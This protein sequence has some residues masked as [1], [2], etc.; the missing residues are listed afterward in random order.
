MAH[1]PWRERPDQAA[2]RRKFGVL[3]PSTNSMVEYDFNWMNVPGV[4]P[5]FSRIHIYDADLS[6]PAQM[7]KL[8][9]QLDESIDYAVDLV[10]TADP[11]YMVMG[12]SAETFWGGKEGNEYFKRRIK[13]R[14]GGLDVATGA[15]ACELALNAFGVKSIAVVTP[16]QAN[17]DEQVDSTSS[18]AASTCARSRASSALPRSRSRRP[19]RTSCARRSSSSTRPAPTPSCRSAPTCAWSASAPRP[20]AGCD[21]PVARDQ[22]RHLVDGA[23]RRTASTTSSTASA[24]SS[25]SSE[26]AARCWMISSSRSSST[27]SACAVA[28]CRVGGSLKRSSDPRRVGAVDGAGVGVLD[29]PPCPPWPWTTIDCSSSPRG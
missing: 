8:R 5:L 12:M 3:A 10:K 28:A 15:E 25:R 13:E 20:S 4:V 24:A 11:D 26:P 23:A 14:S 16:Y 17:G 22:R 2:W 29:R 27:F 1:E 18:S 21:K 6:S 7:E 9:V 19:P